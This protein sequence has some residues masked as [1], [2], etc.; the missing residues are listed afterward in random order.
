[1]KQIFVFLIAITI[2]SCGKD[3]IKKD[4]PDTVVPGN[5]AEAKTELNKIYGKDDNAA[6]VMD[7][8]LPAN[9]STSSTNVILLVHGGAWIA[10]D[11]NGNDD[12]PYIKILLDS[13]RKRYPDWAIFNMNYRLASGNPITGTNA[14]NIFPTQEDDVATAVKY[15]YDNRQAFGISDKWVFMGMSAGAHLV[16]LQAYKSDNGA[17]I[18]PKVV[19]DFYGPTDMADLYNFYNDE[20]EVLGRNGIKMLLGDNTPSSNAQLYSRNSPINAV[21]AQAPPTLILHG[22]NDDTVPERQSLALRDKLKNLSV[23]VEFVAGL[24]EQT[25][26]WSSP[27]SWAKSMKSIQDFLTANVP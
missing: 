8:Y 27:D 16:M 23:K 13:V 9:R 4:D 25:H 6:Q 12:D 20:G 3:K 15:I 7:I 10:G 17:P 1:M 26:G 22:G 2:F 18:R 19:V 21:N 24:K 5:F 14:K 11:K